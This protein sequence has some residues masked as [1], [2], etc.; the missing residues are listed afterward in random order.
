MEDDCE[1]RTKFV[2]SG[3][4]DSLVTDGLPGRR[5]GVFGLTALSLR[6]LG[7]VVSEFRLTTTCQLCRAREDCSED[8][9]RE[10]WFGM[11]ESLSGFAGVASAMG[12]AVSV[13]QIAS[14]VLANTSWCATHTAQMHR[15]KIGLVR[16]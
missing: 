10:V 1:L 4:D 7:L 12:F 14:P 2:R 15:H 8:V 11:D 6:E 3:L 9:F 13:L 16:I 5:F